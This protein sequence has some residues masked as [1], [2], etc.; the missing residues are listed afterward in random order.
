MLRTNFQ[1]SLWRFIA[2]CDKLLFVHSVSLHT[3]LRAASCVHTT[4]AYAHPRLDGPTWRMSSRAIKGPV[5]KRLMTIC[6]EHVSGRPPGNKGP[7]R[8]CPLSFSASEPFDPSSSRTVVGEATAQPAS[9]EQWV[10]PRSSLFLP[11]SFSFP[12]P[13]SWLAG[14]V[15]VSC[16]ARDSVVQLLPVYHTSLLLSASSRSA[17]PRIIVPRRLTVPR[18]PVRPRLRV[19]TEL[20][21]SRE[22]SFHRSVT[23]F[24]IC[25]VERR[26]NDKRGGR[27]DKLLL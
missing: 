15:C 19:S 23:I 27:N 16:A 22:I 25:I 5:G 3:C 2:S 14:A 20:L 21:C 6:P 10:S 11:F 1:I 12:R 26:V 18:D 24:R 4:Y 17:D 13:L 7:L 9:R 8:P